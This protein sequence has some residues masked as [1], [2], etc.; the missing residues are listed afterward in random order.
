MKAISIREMEV[1]RLMAED[2]KP[3][4]F[5]NKFLNKKTLVAS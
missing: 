4:D 5:V 2:K 3:E 1:L